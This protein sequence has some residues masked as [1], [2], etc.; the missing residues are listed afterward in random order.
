MYDAMSKDTQSIT[1]RCPQALW[2]VLEQ[3]AEREDRTVSSVIRV[4]LRK[5]I[6]QQAGLPTASPQKPRLAS[7]SS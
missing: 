3:M 4:L 1:F 2:A 5:Q 7:T 6:R